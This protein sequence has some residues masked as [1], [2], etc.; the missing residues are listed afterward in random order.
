MPTV[1]GQS[2]DLIKGETMWDTVGIIAAVV[3]IVMLIQ[4]LDLTE[5][6]KNRIKGG[7]ASKD[8][9]QRVAELENRLQAVEN[10]KF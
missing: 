10:K 9:E 1:R 7:G 4:L 6:L 5:A 3:A 2:Q 8:L